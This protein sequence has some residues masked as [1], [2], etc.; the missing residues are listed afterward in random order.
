MAAVAVLR[1]VVDHQDFE[2]AGVVLGG[3]RLQRVGNRRLFVVSGHQDRDRRVVHERL[4]RRSPVQQQACHQERIHHAG[5]HRN[6]ADGENGHGPAHD[7]SQVLQPRQGE[8]RRYDGPDEADHERQRK[9]RLHRKVIALQAAV[10]AWL[11]LARV[12]RIRRDLRLCDES[13]LDDLGPSFLDRTDGA[14]D[15]GVLMQAR[16]AGQPARPMGRVATRIADGVT[17]G[18]AAL[19]REVCVSHPPDTRQSVT[20]LCQ[21]KGRGCLFGGLVPVSVSRRHRP[22]QTSC[23][24]TM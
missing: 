5:Q 21:A 20:V 11:I 1:T 16:V 8:Q 7:G 4:A 3:D 12:P 19:L 10:R 6:A 24:Y 15:S 23:S 2:L 17:Q 18:P 22:R 14:M 9:L 13:G